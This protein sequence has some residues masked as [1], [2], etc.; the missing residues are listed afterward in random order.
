MEQ[1]QEEEEGC[2]QMK[3][4]RAGSSCPLSPTLLI[5]HQDLPIEPQ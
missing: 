3:K 1:Q 5:H 4:K 2:S